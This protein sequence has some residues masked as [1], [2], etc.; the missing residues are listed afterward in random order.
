MSSDIRANLNDQIS[1]EAA[2]WLVEYRTGDIDPAGR[3]D[4]DAWLRASPEHVRAFIEMAALWQ[5]GG[6]IDPRRRLNV[7]A[8]IAGA[9]SEQ[10]IVP[11]SPTSRGGLS[12]S[13]PPAPALPITLAH[14]VQES[15]RSGRV[16]PSQWAV[17]AGLL[18]AALA[19]TSILRSRLPSRPTYTTGVGVRQSI[20]LPDGSKVLLDSNSQLR[21]SFTVAMR[22][23]EL[24]HGQAL[25]YVVKNPRQPFLVDAGR[26][27]VRDVGT[28]F[29][30]NR[31]GNGTIVTVVQGRV[32]V[33]MP[34][35]AEARGTKVGVELQ[36]GDDATG[37]G[38]A[39]RKA[40]PTIYLSTGEQVDMHVGHSPPR[41]IRV[42]VDSATA[43]THGEVVLES[44][45]LAEVAQVFNRYSARRLVTEDLGKKPLRLSGVFSTNPDFLIRYLRG[46]PDITV[47]ET[48]SEIGIVRDPTR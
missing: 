7:E 30:V 15:V 29:D 1:R 42:D 13:A 28:V 45:T 43:W 21:V 41:A 25:F 26:T 5:E 24:L 22:K 16:R 23:V 35:N 39:G 44:A 48:D 12:V 8:M 47:R 3:K 46:R 33:A 38:V 34:P 40:A 31:L 10:N 4:F 32:A 17:A 19:M 2:E 20:A 37:I 14:E 6:A 11:M 18:I 36:P 9:Q 27:V